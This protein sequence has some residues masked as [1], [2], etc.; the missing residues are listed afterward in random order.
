MV[1][2]ESKNAVDRFATRDIIAVNMSPGEIGRDVDTANNASVSGSNSALHLASPDKSYRPPKDIALRCDHLIPRLTS[3]KYP[4]HRSVTRSLRSFL[5]VAGCSLP[6]RIWPWRLARPPDRTR[7]KTPIAPIRTPQSAT[8]RCRGCRLPQTRSRIHS[9][10]NAPA[11]RVPLWRDG[12]RL[13]DDVQ[14]APALRQPA[15]TFERGAAPMAV[16]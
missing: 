12:H 1:P 14:I 4:H 16:H 10:V 5:P 6:I 2:A 9:Q 15:F 13:A 8:A 3:T 11:D 7:R